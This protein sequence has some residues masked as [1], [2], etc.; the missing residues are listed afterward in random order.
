MNIKY[1]ITTF[2]INKPC[3]KHV[4]IHFNDD[5]LVVIVV[6]RNQFK[7]CH[8]I[9]LLFRSFIAFSKL[10]IEVATEATIEVVDEVV[11]EVVIPINTFS[12]I[13]W[14]VIIIFFIIVIITK[15]VIIV[16][17]T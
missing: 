5:D 16:I 1:F 13:I 2:I 4:I 6:A 8:K 14:I 9:Q 10:S 3:H 12:F 11:I 7:L 17:I 15:P